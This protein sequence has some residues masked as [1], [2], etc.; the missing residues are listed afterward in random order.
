MTITQKIKKYTSVFMSRHGFAEMKRGF[1]AIRSELALCIDFEKPVGSVYAVCYLMPLFMP[2][3]TRYYTYGRRMNEIKE[4]GL[5]VLLADA[6]D[7]EIERW[8][9]DFEKAM[10]KTVLP[11]FDRVDTP[12]KLS[13]WLAW[14][15]LDNDQFLKCEKR[16]FLRIKLYTHLYL[17]HDR[18]ARQSAKIYRRSLESSSHLTA[19]LKSSLLTEL[20]QTVLLLDASEAERKAYFDHMITDVKSRL[21]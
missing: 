21:F 20:E 17:N 9:T 8:C 10:V 3:E 12:E 18:A 2:A 6:P 7:A 16:H 1:F 19:L 14:S 11:F 4:I 15:W 13:H 5:P